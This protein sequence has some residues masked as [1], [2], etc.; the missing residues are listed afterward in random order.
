MRGSFFG[1]NVSLSGLFTAQRNMDTISHNMANIQT[2]G[3]TRQSALQSASSPIRLFNKTGMVG[4]GS[5]VVS[6][7]RIRDLYLDK[8]YWYQN[9]IMGEWA[10]KASLADQI[11]TR[12]A[13]IDGND[14]GVAMN[15]FYSALQ[16]L[17]KD[18]S[19]LSIRSVVKE[20]ALSLTSYFNNLAANLEKMQ[21]DIN[22][23]VKAKV[24]LVNSI[25]HRIESLNQ[26]I[27]QIEILGEAANDLRDA[28]DLLIDELSGLVNVEVGEHNYGKLPSGA[29]DMRLY[30]YIG[31]TQFLQHFSANSSTVNELRC[32][33]RAQKLNEEDVNGLYDVVWT[34]P[35]GS[36]EPVAISGGEL[37]G[38]LDMR[39]GNSGL[40][41][42]TKFDLLTQ[43]PVSISVALSANGAALAP[44]TISFSEYVRNAGAMTAG[45]LAAHIQGQLN[46]ALAAAGHAITQ[47]NMARAR[48]TA[49]GKLEIDLGGL[50]SSV[51]PATIDG[52]AVT[53]PAELKQK[54]D[55]AE[56]LAGDPPLQALTSGS[57]IVNATATRAYKGVPYY[58]RKLNE[59]V[60]T[61]AMA[62]NEGF[63]DDNSDKQITAGEVLTGH[64]SGYN[65][66]QGEGEPPA[67]VRFFTMMDSRGAAL[68]TG[69]FLMTSELRM[70][71]LYGLDPDSQEYQDNINAIWNAYQGVT[72]KNFCV[73]ADIASDV[74]LIATSAS[75]GDV[76]DNTNLLAVT[77][78]RFNRHMFSE[79]AAED[80]MQALSTD[81][82]VDTNQAEF[83]LKN[84]T[85]FINLLKDSRVSISGVSEDE[86]FAN[87]IRH[88]HA[89]NASAMMINTFNEIYDT[90]INGLGL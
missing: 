89:Y 10:Q 14:Y 29:D 69:D 8:K 36:A 55:L 6:V 75:A 50:V 78:Q 13:G 73:S 28:R 5:E 87:L 2:P 24:D 35:A 41:Q 77:S 17:S 25:G 85:S 65:I 72:A 83:K 82:A 58:Q 33:A 52:F 76:E 88:Q 53:A 26:Q 15:D 22:I 38:L 68:G 59:Y 60:R 66:G 64:A 54:L 56:I 19:D 48:T 74:G 40:T 34:K 84:Q 21:E 44:L 70:P 71:S 86:E 43:P 20:E 81:S 23:D 47:D 49:D 51:P 9:T 42:E 57:D 31:G 16:E 62:F 11:Q 45:E 1:L 4:T 30:I 32:V 3:Y 46:A 39:D 79:G 27:Y 90:L 18:P 12:V 7:A 61:Y 67:A 80:F 63:M 37:R